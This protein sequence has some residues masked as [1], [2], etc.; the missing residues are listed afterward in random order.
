[1]CFSSVYV[2]NY[3]GSLRILVN[4]DHINL[5][6]KMKYLIIENAGIIKKIIEMY[7]LHCHPPSN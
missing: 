6:A 2:V 7:R 1:M 5:N 4:I 3:D